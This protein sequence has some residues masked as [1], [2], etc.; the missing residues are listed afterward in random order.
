M[1]GV[2]DKIEY[3][4][5]PYAEAFELTEA[6]DQGVEWA[7]EVQEALHGGLATNPEDAALMVEVAWRGGHSNHLELG[8]LFGGSAILM[9]LAKERFGF[10]GE[11]HC[12]DNFGYMRDTYPVGPE[13]VLSN[14]KRF[15]VDDRIKIIKANTYPLPLDITSSVA[16]EGNYGSCMID[17][18]HDFGNCQRDWTSVHP[19]SDVVAFHDYDR[20]HMGVVSTVRNAMQESGW[21]LVFLAHHTA[22]FER[23]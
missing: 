18:S 13:M 14:A 23:L 8:T 20:S 4:A 22:V 19:I 10:D 15:G 1:I 7:K 6:Y 5:P 21:W 16:R 11:I 17:A 2:E 3:V 9:A 12:V